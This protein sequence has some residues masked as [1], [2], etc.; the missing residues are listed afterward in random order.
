MRVELQ[1][2]GG[3]AYFPGLSKPVVVNSADLP[4]EQASE[5][6]QLIDDSHFFELPAASRSLPK[7]AADMRSYTITV[8]VG[9]RRSTVRL[10]DPIEDERLQAL[11]DFL[12]DQRIS[13]ARASD[14]ATP[15]DSR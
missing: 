10:V 13:Q 3:I 5:L 12:Q 9:R 2:E 11:I 15:S 6:Q 1:I 4:T 14:S 8:E 7:G